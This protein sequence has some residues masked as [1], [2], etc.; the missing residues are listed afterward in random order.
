MKHTDLVTSLQHDHI[1][2]YLFPYPLASLYRQMRASHQ[3]ADRFG[4]T[5]LLAEGLFRFLALVNLADALGQPEENRPTEKRIKDWLQMLHHP[6]LGKFLGLLRSTVH[7][8]DEQSSTPFLKETSTLFDEDTWKETSNALV[9]LRND[10]SHIRGHISNEEAAPLLEQST[11]LLE[12][13]L[14]H[15]H[16]LQHYQLGRVVDLQWKASNNCFTFQ[17]YGYRGFDDRG[18]PIPLQSQKPSDGEQILL[19]CSERDQAL[20]LGP[21]FRWAVFPKQN[22]H[23][24]LYW[25]HE[26]NTAKDEVHY[27]LSEQRETSS[28]SLSVHEC[29]WLGCT[30]MQ[31][32][33]ESK[34]QL[35]QS[36]TLIPVPGGNPNRERQKNRADEALKQAEEHREKHQYQQAQPLYE[37]AITIY[38]MLGD[39]EVNIKL[40]LADASNGQGEVQRNLGA[41]DNSLASFDTAQLLY[42]E[43]IQQEER[44][45]LRTKLARCTMNQASSLNIQGKFSEAYEGYQYAIDMYTQLI[46]G[47]GRI[48]L[49]PDLAICLMNQAL[50]LNNQGKLSEAYKTHQRAIDLYTRLVQKEGQNELR[51]SLAL[52]IMNQSLTLKNQ[53]NL[54]EAYEG[55]Q[56][57]I[58]IYIQLIRQERRNEVRPDFAICLMN[59]ASF[60]IKVGHR[61]L[62]QF[63]NEPLNCTR[64]SFNRKGDLNYDPASPSVL[65]IKRRCFMTR[66]N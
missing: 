42:K 62:R 20:Y 64:N 26:W 54:V 24:H 45:E 17:W 19:L 8:F 38:E 28:L 56:H 49:H 25:L 21:C 63:I 1:R 11:P 3:P 13:L 7:W 36:L 30:E 57:A 52:C 6:G 15:C 61:K 41:L 35:Q 5:L 47:E 9:K 53:G 46:Q 32:S 10:T 4:H 18:E 39:T 37:R 22:P 23:A 66:E 27:W 55:Y 2:R 51:S 44:N 43:L 31:L 12:T 58:D 59:Q 29:Q 34:L 50:T 65:R 60:I 33:D 40:Q 48:E 14:M 16:F